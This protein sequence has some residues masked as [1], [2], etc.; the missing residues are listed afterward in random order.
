MVLGALIT[1]TEISET[2]PREESCGVSIGPLNLQ[3]IIPHQAHRLNVNVRRDCVR[4]E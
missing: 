2:L 4:I 1:R 3:R